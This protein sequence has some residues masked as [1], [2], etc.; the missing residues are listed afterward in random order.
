MYINGMQKNINDRE[1]Y[2]GPTLTDYNV[3]KF[4]L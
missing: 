2:Y 4:Q 3:H 1:A